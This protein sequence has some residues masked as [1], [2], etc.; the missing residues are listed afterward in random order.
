MEGSSGQKFWKGR[1]RLPNDFHN[2]FIVPSIIPNC[3]LLTHCLSYLPSPQRRGI[4]AR[5]TSGSL[6]SKGT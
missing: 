6:A 4:L 5:S 1:L 3:S 2:S